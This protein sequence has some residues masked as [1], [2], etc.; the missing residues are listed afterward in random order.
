[1]MNTGSDTLKGVG[2]ALLLLAAF[3]ML[4]QVWM[5]LAQRKTEFALLRSLG[6]SSKKLL[7]LITLELGILV[8]TAFVF[9]EA[10]A[11]WF[12]MQFSDELGYGQ[13]YAFDSS[14]W[15]NF[16]LQLLG[17]PCIVVFVAAMLNARKI[18]QINIADLLQNP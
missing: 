12:L 8:F 16:D 18:Y 14:K 10:L 5:G 15:S 3:S 11:R 7:R 1:M 13:A 17:L 4:V 6:Y 2:I 9:G